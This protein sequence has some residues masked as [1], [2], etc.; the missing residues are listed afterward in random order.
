MPPND[1]RRS[2]PHIP[3]RA[4]LRPVLG[5]D[6]SSRQQGGDQAAAGVVRNQINAIFEQGSNSTKTHD[7]TSTAESFAE[8]SHTS[9]DSPYDRTHQADRTNLHTDQ[10][11]QYHSAWQD[12]YK[13]YYERFYLGEVYRMQKTLEMPAATNSQI[14]QS[15]PEESVEN[16]EAFRNLRYDL[17]S[18]VRESAS[19]A[20][21]SR[22]FMP[23]VAAG[24][25]MVLFLFLQ[26]NRVLFSNVEAYI[27]PGSINPTNI[28]VDPNISI[29]ISKEPRLIIPKINV[30]VPV[31]YDTK[32]DQNSQ[33]KAMES[34]VAWFGI[35]GA[36]SRPGQIGNTVLSGHSSNDLF[37]PGDY[38]F[39]FAR[40]D[41]LAQGDTFYVNYLGTRYTYSIT[42][43]EVVKPTDVHK[44]V[45]DTNGKPIMTLI[46]CVP[47]GTAQNRLLVTA[48]QVS[49]DPTEAQ[50]APD[51]STAENEAAMPGNSPTFLN[52]LFGS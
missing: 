13:Q 19:K 14:P 22:H 32:P 33:L 41:Q 4:Y 40:L 5:D 8:T 34:G 42:K 31:V 35:P 36:N 25:T 47:L 38:K 27:S 24:L 16:E 10:W 20:R 49:P 2:R 23:F 39:I 17:L 52:R 44:L 43:K 50:Q 11:K 1:P 28:I 37:D 29:P 6:T 15:Q 45:Y 21:N 12:Y 3:Q 26:Y 30:D 46:T 9:L 48:E 7:Q 18:N 51:D